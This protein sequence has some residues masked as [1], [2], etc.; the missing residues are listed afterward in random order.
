MA[1]SNPLRFGGSLPFCTACR[2]CPE[3]A[4]GIGVL[5]NVP[6]SVINMRGRFEAFRQGLRE[7]GYVE[8]RNV[9]FQFRYPRTISGRV[10]ELTRLASELVRMRPHVIFTHSSPATDVLRKATRTIPIV[11]GVG[12]DRHVASYSHPGGNITGLSSIAQNLLGKQLQ[13]FREA[14]PRMTRVAI[15]WNPDHRSHAANV[16]K[17]KRASTILGLDLIPVGLTDG[18]S[19]NAAFDLML[20]EKVQ[21]VLILRGGMLVNLR[22]RISDKATAMALPTMFGHPSEARAGGLLAYGTNVTAMYRRAATYVDKILKGAKA[23]DLPVERPTK[24]DMIVNL[25]TARKLGVTIPSSILLRA[26][27]VIE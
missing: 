9:V 3:G 25:K 20:A 24:F 1:R 10:A 27:E 2:P 18:K 22:P 4:K 5:A 12:V 21:G 15:L 8:G 16:K 23:G 19:L 7:L 17:A 26:D 11:V 6:K 14:F 13:I